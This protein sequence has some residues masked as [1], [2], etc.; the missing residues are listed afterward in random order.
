M[1][2]LLER[3]LL[4]KP[5]RTDHGGLRDREH[6]RFRFGSSAGLDLDAAWIPQNSERA[7][8]FLHGNRHNITKF[9]DHYNLFQTL[10]LS[11]LAFDYPGYGASTGT[12]SEEGLYR[13][14]HAAYE[15]LRDTLGFSPR[16]ILVY[17]FSLGGAVA[18][19]LLQNHPA[20]ALITESTFTNSHA[21]ARHLYPFLPITG[22]LPNRFT[23]D[24]RIQNLGS[25]CLLIHGEA[26]P[27]VPPRMANELHTLALPPKELVT[28]PGAQHTNSLVCGAEE[29][30]NRIR[31]FVLKHVGRA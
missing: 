19:E 13:S 3:L 26:D 25:P 8:L 1:F 22:F 9:A 24:A 31:A 2:Q 28:V 27:V 7:V 11:C 18:L 12:P 30:T 4:F 29:L 5:D 15:H 6:S 20:A 14:A 17:G 16:Q 10:Q 23:N 21:M